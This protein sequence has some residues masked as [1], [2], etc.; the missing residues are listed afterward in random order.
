MRASRKPTL[1]EII[2]KMVGGTSILYDPSRPGGTALTDYHAAQRVKAALRKKTLIEQFAGV[3]KA[4]AGFHCQ[5][6][7]RDGVI[8][9][10]KSGAPET[11]IEIGGDK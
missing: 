10:W 11:Y 3:K 1:N 2:L 7:I 8:R 5:A 9:V 4:L 6:T